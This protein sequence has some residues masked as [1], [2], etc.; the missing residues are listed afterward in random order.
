M[1][2][3][4]FL[5]LFL[6]LSLVLFFSFSLSPCHSRISKFFNPAQLEVWFREGMHA[7]CAFDRVCNCVSVW[8]LMGRNG[9]MVGMRLCQL[10]KITRKGKKQCLH[11]EKERKIWWE[12][13]KQTEDWA[14]N[15]TKKKDEREKEM[16]P[17]RNKQFDSQK[18]PQEREKRMKWSSMLLRIQMCFVFCRFSMTSFAVSRWFILVNC[19]RKRSD[20]LGKNGWR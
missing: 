14:N 8:W 11:Y 2:G 9:G 4:F 1:T 15:G 18:A 3:P 6:S 17:V 7:P 12:S 10:K 13:V 5:S 16:I 19:W 20:N